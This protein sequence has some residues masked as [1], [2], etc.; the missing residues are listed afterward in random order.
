[1]DERTV[2]DFNLFLHVWCRKAI[3]GRSTNADVLRRQSIPSK[4]AVFQVIEPRTVHAC[5]HEQHGG[6]HGAHAR[7]AMDEDVT[8]SGKF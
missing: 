5:F 6:H 7:L 4:D 2:A 1:M 3:R 8:F